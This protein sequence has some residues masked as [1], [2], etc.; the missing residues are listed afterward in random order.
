M[1]K[2]RILH[3]DCGELFVGHRA[4]GGAE[5]DRAGLQLA[6]TAARADRLIV[7]LNVGVRRVVDVK[8]FRIDGVGERSAGGVEEHGFRLALWRAGETPW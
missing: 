7:N 4:I 3:F 6:N 8:P 1:G 5:I 2:W